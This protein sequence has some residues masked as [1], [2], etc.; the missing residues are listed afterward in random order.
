MDLVYKNEKPLFTIAAVLSGLFWLAL[1]LGTLGIFLIYALFAWLI[2][3]FAHSAFISHL[4]GSGVKITPEQYPDLHA[5]LVR[6]C[7]KIGLT[8]VPDAYLLRTDFFNALATRFLGRSFVVLFTDVVDAL[9][10]RPDA[11]DF[12]IGH[13]LGHIHRN[14]LVWKP[15]LMP[16]SILPLLGPALRRAEE[17]TCDRYGTA[18]CEHEDDVKAALAAIAAGDTRWKTINVDAYLEQTKNTNG[19]WMSFHELT[20]DYPWLTKRMATALALHRGKKITHPSR[21]GLAWLLALMIPRTGAGGGIASIIIVIAVIGIL[22]AVAIPAYQDYTQRATAASGYE[23][24]SDLGTARAATDTSENPARF[25]AAYA[26]AYPLQQEIT[27]YAIENQEWPASLE[28]LGYPSATIVNSEHTYDIDL[29]DGG[30]IGVWMGSDI[31]NE[32]K[33]LVMEPQVNEE[34]QV[35]WL[36]Y[37]ENV[38]AALLPVNCQ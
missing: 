28:N 12:Y 30:M 6:S 11:I 26:Q 5:K 33:Y 15:L 9:E 7:E 37:G 17:Y 36:C 23:A 25:E 16:A 21:H 19:F 35:N 3:L 27:N 13:E 34:G 8:E 31:N 29:Y 10:D 18:C 2:F 22:A 32:G 20:G 14:H 24:F 4:K 1:V 38:D